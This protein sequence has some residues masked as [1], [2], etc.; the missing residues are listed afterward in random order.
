MLLTAGCSSSHRAHSCWWAVVVAVC[1]AVGTLGLCQDTELS[2]C[3]PDCGQLLPPGP[4]ALPEELMA[5]GQPGQPQGEAQPAVPALLS[6]QLPE[7]PPLPS[8]MAT[9]Q[10]MEK[11]D[12]LLVSL[13]NQGNN[14]AGSF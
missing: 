13:Q 6:Q 14:M 10:N 9:N 2:L 7:T 11:I 4:A 5:M 3:P 1:F 12:D 8:A